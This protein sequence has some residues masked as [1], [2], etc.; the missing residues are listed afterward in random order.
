VREKLTVLRR[1][2][3]G[4]SVEVVFNGWVSFYL[5]CSCP[6]WGSRVSGATFNLRIFWIKLAKIYLFI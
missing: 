4:V 2:A 5:I 1:I 3:K 6:F